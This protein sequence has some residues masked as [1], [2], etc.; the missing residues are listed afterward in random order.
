MSLLF[1]GFG[2]QC[3]P[4]MQ[5]RRKFKDKNRTRNWNGILFYTYPESKP[6]QNGTVPFF[7]TCFYENAY[8]INRANFP[9]SCWLTEA[10]FLLVK[11]I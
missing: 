9:E 4:P 6:S 7:K 10:Q 1:K 8:R 3:L 2:E 5:K 11:W